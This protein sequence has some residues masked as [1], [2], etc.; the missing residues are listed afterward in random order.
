MKKIALLISLAAGLRMQAQFSIS[1]KSDAAFA[2][3]EAYLYTLSGSKDILVSKIIKNENS[4]AFRYPKPYTGIMKLYFPESNATL[5]FISENKD[6]DINFT[7]KNNKVAEINYIDASNKA[8]DEIQSLQRRREV[9]LPA[10]YEMADYYKPSSEFAAA[11][12]KEIK[13][14]TS[15]QTQNLDAYPFVNFYNTNYNRFLVTR[16]GAAKPSQDDII[17]FL[18][19]SDERLE[20][21]SLIGS[22]LTTYLQNSQ[23]NAD[24]AVRKLLTAVKIESPR[25]Q[26][27]LSELIDI[28]DSY[29][30]NELKT[31]YLA[32]AEGLK[33]TI[34]DRLAST[35][36]SNKNTEIGAAFPDYKFQAP[37]NTAAKTLYGVKAAKKVVVFWSSTCSHCETELPQLLP[38]YNTLKSKNI[39]I[40]GLSLDTDKTSYESKISNYPWINDSEL[41]G[42]YSNFAETYNVHATPTYFILDA[43][44][45]IIAKPDHVGDV[46]QELG[47]K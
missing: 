6:V 5:R 24:A 16:P 12:E 44:N 28:F 37:T 43:G 27:I 23:T 20:G 36:K 10:L 13:Q 17:N 9:I 14:L 22:V 18:N 3:K 38:V 33:C 31:K 2:P 39:E 30:M 25:G 1:V 19:S 8:M 7:S 21:S 29:G 32:E 34:T 42:W 15:G 11:I 35:I 40:V 45:K 4:W 47:V 41:R 46:L 26:T